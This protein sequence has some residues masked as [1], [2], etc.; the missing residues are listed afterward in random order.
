MNANSQI[1]DLHSQVSSLQ[2]EN[3]NKQNQISSL[4]TQ[5][6]QLNGEINNVRTEAAQK[7]AS[8]EN[9]DHQIDSLN[10]QIS[11]LASQVNEL[12][13][14]VSSLGGQIAHLKEAYI[15]TALGAKEILESTPYHLYI[16]GTVINTGGGTAYN[17]GLHVVAYNVN[18]SLAINMTVSFFGTF[19]NGPGVSSGVQLEML[20]VAETKN[21]SVNIFHEGIL[22]TWDITPVSTNTP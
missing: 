6:E 19:G 3:A 12:N 21:V 4:N 10:S 16:S 14:Q 2:S 5:I 20:P 22:G 13:S 11:S 17:A 15:V 9:K 8:L 7:D 1:G 18:G